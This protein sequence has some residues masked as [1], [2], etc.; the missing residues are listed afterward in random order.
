MCSKSEPSSAHK[1]KA[2]VDFYGI[3][4]D[5]FEPSDI[6][7]YSVGIALP[8]RETLIQFASVQSFQKFFIR[9]QYGLHI[10]LD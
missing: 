5:Q 2:F 3:D 1:I 10:S 4:M 9:H 8:S 6:N 7:A